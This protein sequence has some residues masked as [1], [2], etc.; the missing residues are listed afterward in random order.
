MCFD[1]GIHGYQ[2][3]CQWVDNGVQAL[4]TRIK[5]SSVHELYV[6]VNE[7]IERNRSL[8]FWGG[9][10]CCLLITPKIFLYGASSGAAIGAGATRKSIRAYLV[11]ELGNSPLMTLMRIMGHV[12]IRCLH[13]FIQVFLNGI[14]VGYHVYTILNGEKHGHALYAG[15]CYE[16]RQIYCEFM[17]WVPP[18]R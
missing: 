3:V 17:Q 18:L 2:E 13:S 9:A 12:G 5:K 14:C 11:P 10:F 8:I 7:L 4:Q 16:S 15:L 1:W 6:R